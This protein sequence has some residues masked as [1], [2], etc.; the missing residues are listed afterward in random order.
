MYIYIPANCTSFHMK[1]RQIARKLYANIK[2][3]QLTNEIYINLLFLI[4]KF[5]LVLRYFR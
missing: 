3:V 1:T 4:F 2:G 5:L